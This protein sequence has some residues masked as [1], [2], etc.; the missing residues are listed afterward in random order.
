MLRKLALG[1][2]ILRRSLWRIC[3]PRARVRAWDCAPV[4]R[5]EQFGS[6]FQ[7]LFRMSDSQKEVWCHTFHLPKKNICR[8][9]LSFSLLF[10]NL[11]FMSPYP[12]PPTPQS[13]PRNSSSSSAIATM[14]NGPRFSANS[15]LM[16]YSIPKAAEQQQPAKPVVQGDTESSK[17]EVRRGNSSTRTRQ[18]E[19]QIEAL[20]LQNVKLQR[21]NRLLKIDT[22]NLIK[23]KTQPLEQ[24]IRELTFANV[25]LQRATRL[26]QQD[27]EEK[28]AVME[29]YKQEQ[30]T[31]M[32]SVGPE[33]EFLVQM[34]NLLHRQVRCQSLS[35]EANR[36]IELGLLD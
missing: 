29:Q 12:L 26:L 15:N 22:D 6:R 16:N 5:H 3:A 7:W 25:Q 17:R 14:A 21:T 8:F 1:S 33:Y 19:S 24:T 10:I 27:L 34:V 20:T 23:Q 11:S 36:C 35:V 4:G 31:K 13:T 30:I 2:R 28:T 32:K 18:L 9:S